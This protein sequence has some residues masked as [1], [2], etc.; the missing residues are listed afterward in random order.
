MLTK[1][2]LEELREELQTCKRPLIFFHD[3]PD[4][5][6]SFL[7]FYRFVGDGKGIVLKTATEMG[8]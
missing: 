5:L 6:T 8:E 1:E 3:D 2:Q 7:L 4:G